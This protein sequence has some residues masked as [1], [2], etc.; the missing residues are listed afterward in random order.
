M[1]I[2]SVMSKIRRD[3]RNKK[4]ILLFSVLTTADYTRTKMKITGEIYKNE[5]MFVMDIVCSMY[6]IDHN[7]VLQGSKKPK[8]CRSRPI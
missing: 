7:T 6:N 5:Q 4:R 2:N 3:F 8:I 1:F